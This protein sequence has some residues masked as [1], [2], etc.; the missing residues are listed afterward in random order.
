[1]TTNL[2]SVRL[3][4]KAK[5][6]RGLADSSRLAILE[7]LRAGPLNVGAIVERTGLSQPN[8]SNHLTCLSECGLVQRDPRGR[9]VY[10]EIADVRVRTL[11]SLAEDLLESVEAEVEAC[12]N[13]QE[14]QERV[15]RP[16]DGDPR[17]GNGHR[18]R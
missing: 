13:Y 14:G 6:F 16:E 9:F 8:T 2:A 12:R 1:M 17:S 3:P 18:G 10:Y 11:L 15:A 4:L 5:L 7:A